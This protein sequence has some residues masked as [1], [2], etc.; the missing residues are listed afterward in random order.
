[1]KI[2]CTFVFRAKESLDFEKFPRNL[3]RLPKSQKQNAYSPFHIRLE[4]SLQLANPHFLSVNA[5]VVPPMKMVPTQSHIVKKWRKLIDIMP[6][7][8]DLKKLIV[9]LLPFVKI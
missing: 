2:S 3:T 6:L 5:P 1:M 8:L 9:V 7:C 4:A